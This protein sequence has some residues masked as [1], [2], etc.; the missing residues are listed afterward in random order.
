MRLIFNL[1]LVLAVTLTVGATASAQRQSPSLSSSLCAG[2]VSWQTAKTVVGRYATV[3]GRVAG[4]KF[5][6]ASN[7][8]PTFLNLG[9]DYPSA[10]R[11]TVVIWMKNRDKFGVPEARYKGH[12]ICVHGYV[13]SYRGV[14]EIEATDPSQIFVSR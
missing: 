10:K 5:A 9:V 14:P 4:S 6:S 12:T 7:G 8:S 13:D 2:A 3:K 11:F 1:L